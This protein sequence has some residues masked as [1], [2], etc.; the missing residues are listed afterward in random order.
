MPQGYTDYN[1]RL[2]G[3]IND[4]VDAGLSDADVNDLVDRFK[5]KYPQQTPAEQ[6]RQEATD[7][8]AAYLRDTIA[9][10][11][12]DALDQAK[13]AVSTLGTLAGATGELGS[14][15]GNRVREMVG[16]TPHYSAGTPNIDKVESALPA[17]VQHY[18]GYLDPNQRAL[19]VRDHPVGLVADIE[20][21]KAGGEG[22]AAGGRAVADA[23]Q[24]T[25][26][27]HPDL[28]A[29]AAGAAEGYHYGGWR[30]ALI[31]AVSGYGLPATLRGVVKKVAQAGAD[32]ATENPNA[33]GRLISKTPTLEET[34]RTELESLR[35]TPAGSSRL[36]GVAAPSTA[37]G[38]LT[39]A[40][41]YTAE[42][43]N[44]Q[45]VL[46]KQ[47]RDEAA[48]VKAPARQSD[49][50]TQAANFRAARAHG[51]GGFTEVP[52]LSQSELDRISNNIDA[53]LKKRS[54]PAVVSTAPEP[55]AAAATVP[56]SGMP[57]L[58]DARMEEL[59]RRFGGTSTVPAPVSGSIREQLEAALRARAGR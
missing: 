32:A 55:A 8:P 37:D 54:L 30:G 15:I 12:K 9:N 29:A 56:S 35:D 26:V 23:A 22:I 47:A 3:L 20:G 11:P 27:D 34:L 25:I 4:A 36:P 38:R 52:A 39:D 16:L 21:A 13:G 1:D 45:R 40:N 10:V 7:H 28:A 44:V 59:A 18:A 51:V 24:Q 58:S 43:P 49:L 17:I 31:G 41:L 53:I 33:G 48:A 57:T 5:A 50:D 46:Q 6:A 42:T 19:M 2:K 14:A